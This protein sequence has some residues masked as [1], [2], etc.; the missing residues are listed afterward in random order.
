MEWIFSHLHYSITVVINICGQTNINGFVNFTKTSA[1]KTQFFDITELWSDAID[2]IRCI[3]NST[4]FGTG[5]KQNVFAVVCYDDELKYVQTIC[6]CFSS[7][8]IFSTESTIFR[9]S[10]SL[11]I[12][13]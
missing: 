8:L 3:S 1:D 6:I 11:V 12:V 13:K 9:N 7:K 2:N 10:P 5:L 4:S